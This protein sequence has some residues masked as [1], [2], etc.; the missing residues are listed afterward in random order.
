MMNKV[1]Y[2][3]L[4]ITTLQVSCKFHMAVTDIG[5]ETNYV[6]A[7]LPLTSYVLVVLMLH[8]SFS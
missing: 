1:V 7:D 5:A 4:M 3:V 8:F 6:N 2:I